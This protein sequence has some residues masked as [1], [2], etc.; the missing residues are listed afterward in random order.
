VK[1][2]LSFLGKPTD[3]LPETVLLA[4][5]AVLTMSSKRDVYYVTTPK[6]CS[7]PSASWRPGKACKHQRKHFA[8]EARGPSPSSTGSTRVKWAGGHNGPVLDEALASERS[9]LGDAPG[10]IDLSEPVEV[11]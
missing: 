9:M 5:G 8:A 1:A 6:S 11:A 2:L 10:R 7:C 4:N 3:P